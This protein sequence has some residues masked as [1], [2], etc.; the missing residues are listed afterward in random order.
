MNSIEAGSPTS[1]AAK[2][3]VLAEA[4][5]QRV[6]DRSQPVPKAVPAALFE[7]L[8]TLEAT[9]R[10]L[11]VDHATEPR[12]PRWRRIMGNLTA[13]GYYVV[14]QLDPDGSVWVADGYVIDRSAPAGLRHITSGHGADREEALY[15]LAGELGVSEQQQTG[16]LDVETMMK[17]GRY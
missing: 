8:N 6:L 7:A 2:A 13:R 15:Q 9:E 16:D 17:E 11:G 12:R 3:Y 5:F 14:V 10:L 1:Q 4:A